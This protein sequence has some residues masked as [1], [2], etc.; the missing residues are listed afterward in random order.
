MSLLNDK[1]AV[2]TGGNGG[3]GLGMVKT[4]AQAGASVAIPEAGRS[5]NSTVWQCRTLLR[6]RQQLYSGSDS[7][8]PMSS[9]NRGVVPIFDTNRAPRLETK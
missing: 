3:I 1:V 9:P 7:A 4:M 8:E 5:P 6:Q 2:V